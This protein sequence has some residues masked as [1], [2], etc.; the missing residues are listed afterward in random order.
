MRKFLDISKKPLSIGC[1]A[2]VLYII[3]ALIGGLFIEGGSFM[4]VAFAYWTVFFGAT[5]S[6]R[7]R[8][9]IGTIIGYLSAILMMLITSSF[10]LNLHTIS[11]SCLLGVFLVNMLVMYFEHT[12]KCWTN[13]ISGIFV[14]IMLV[15][16]G[17][18]RGLNP[19]N[20]VAEAGTM[21]LIIL[22]YCVLGMFCGF[23]SL[24]FNRA[25]NVEVSS[26]EVAPLEVEEEQVVE[27]V[28]KS[29]TKKTSAKKTTK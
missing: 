3:D 24:Y 25:K 17:L 16:S 15:F 23:F 5:V 8:G 21:L 20:G 7:I 18:G 11:I 27:E 12:E 29:T 2:A 28:K 1:I 22:V 9:F 14:G 26:G 19:L 6:D 13:N 4:W 10:T